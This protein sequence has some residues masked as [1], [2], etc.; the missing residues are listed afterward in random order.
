[1][2]GFFK[3][4]KAKEEAIRAK[5]QACKQ[6]I[7]ALQGDR[8]NA[9]EGALVLHFTE[10]NEES[11]TRFLIAFGQSDVWMLNNG[12]DRLG[13]PAVTQGSDGGPYVAVFSSNERATAAADEWKLTNRS[14]V[15]SALELVFGLSPAVG[16]VINANDPHIQ[17]SF[18]PQNVSNLRTLFERSHNYEVGG[19]YSVWGRGTY[20]V[21]KIL[22]VDEG[23]VHLRM[24]ANT[25]QERP[26][27]IDP[28]TLTLTGEDAGSIQAIGHMPV[29][30]SNFLSMGP[31]LAASSPVTDAE[32]EGYRMWEEAKGGYFGTP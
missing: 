25:W 4:R 12:S 29:V 32:L 11:L 22:N 17:W 21:I 2:F 7:L 31:R 28:D 23:G 1:M 10:Q 27:T 3:K 8:G 5:V 20:K 13:D 24:Y 6:V 9:L 18:P 16:I 26:S 15:I 14:S 30:R 19:I